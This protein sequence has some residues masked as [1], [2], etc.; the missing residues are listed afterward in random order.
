MLYPVVDWNVMI[1]SKSF[2]I[3]LT[4]V[5]IGTVGVATIGFAQSNAV[6]DSDTVSRLDIDASLDNDTIIVSVLDEGAPVEN[7]VVTV[8]GEEDLVIVTDENGTARVSVSQ[9]ADEDDAVD[10]LEIEYETDSAEGELEFIIRDDTLHL[11]E[12]SYEYE[13]PESLE[14]E[15]EGD[16]HD[17]DPEVEEDEDDDEEEDDEEQEDDDEDDEADDD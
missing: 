8:E 4:A 12:E 7:A 2:L 5:L 6:N 15:A 10:E 13:I 9:L 14:D 1:S 3:V 16:D 11:V 17:D